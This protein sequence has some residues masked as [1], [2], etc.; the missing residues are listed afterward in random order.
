M[1]FAC[2]LHADRAVG[3]LA[4]SIGGVIDVTD[5]AVRSTH[6]LARFVAQHHRILVA[7]EPAVLDARMRV[8][9]ARLS[10]TRRAHSHFVRREHSARL[11]RAFLAMSLADET[12]RRIGAP[13]MRRAVDGLIDRARRSMMLADGLRA[14]RAARHLVDSDVLGS[15]AFAFRH[16]L[17]AETT[18]AARR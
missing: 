9:V 8:S 4:D 1:R 2:R 6:E 16:A 5:R 15:A 7:V 14:R 18:L 3:G 12:T 17:G 10:A 13:K 11:E